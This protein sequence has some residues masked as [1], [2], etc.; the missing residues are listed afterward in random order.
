LIAPVARSLKAD[1]FFAGRLV[2]LYMLP[3]GLSA[4]LYG[5][6][7]RTVESK[8]ILFICLGLFSLANLVAGLACNIQTLL[9]GRVL[10][11][12]A[13]AA[14]I[15]LSLIL[16][17]KTSLP[18]QRGKRVGEFFSLTFI[19]SLLGLFLS[20]VLP[21][22]WLFL[23]PA[24]AAGLV[25]WGIYYYFPQQGINKERLKFNYFQ[26]FKDKQVLRLFI[27]IF[28]VSFLYHGIRQWLGVYFFKVYC[29]GQF[30]LSMLLTSVSLS[31]VFGEFLGGRLADRLGR[32][33]VIN[34]GIS[35]M[36]FALIALLFKNIL[37]SLFVIMF[38]WGIGW[39]F[40]HAGVSTYLTDLPAK[41]LYESASLN[42][43][44]RFLAGGLGMVFGALLA[45]RDFNLQFLVFSF[46]L[47]LL[48]AFSK[49]LI[50]REAQ[51]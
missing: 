30:M 45:R 17:A 29:L 28:A 13:G 46:C 47:V 33:K 51:T 1:E 41:H 50:L 11:G 37:F 44:V 3:Y 39:T 35:L 4:L 31:G 42:S 34:I 40:N 26:V 21:W 14:I 24:V 7:A 27:Y 43:S 9:V 38:I 23:L 36:I 12:A 18:N 8:K 49:K 48:L 10:A 6:L 25:C 20:G 15:P 5:P 19:S 2:W 16:I 22:R 32:Q